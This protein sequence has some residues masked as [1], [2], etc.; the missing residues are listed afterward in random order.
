MPCSNRPLKIK[1]VMGGAGGRH[2]SEKNMMYF[3]TM[4]GFVTFGVKYCDAHGLLTVAH[5]HN[6]QNRFRFVGF[7]PSWSAVGLRSI[8]LQDDI[9]IES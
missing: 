7:D 8:V 5:F 9:T 3:T 1:S 6:K 4:K 2:I